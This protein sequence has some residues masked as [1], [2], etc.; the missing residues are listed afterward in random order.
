MLGSLGTAKAWC[1]S[2][3]GPMEKIEKSYVMLLACLCQVFET[4]RDRENRKRTQETF[5]FLAS[6]PF[7][8]TLAGIVDSHLS[9]HSQIPWAVR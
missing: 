5:L 7:R 8:F 1:L 9:Q 6:W 2:L 3:L 4:E